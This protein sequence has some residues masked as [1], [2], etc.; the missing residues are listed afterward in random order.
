ML[1]RKIHTLC[2]LLRGLL[3][4]DERISVNSHYN[5]FVEILFTKNTLIAEAVKNIRSYLDYRARIIC[6]ICHFKV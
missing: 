4:F 1:N 5:I 3:Y 2:Q 6:L